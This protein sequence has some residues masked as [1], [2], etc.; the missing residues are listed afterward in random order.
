MLNW[1]RKQQEKLLF[2]VISVLPPYIFMFHLYGKNT[3]YVSYW[4]FLIFSVVLSLGGLLVYWAMSKIGKSRQ[5]SALACVFLWVMFFTIKPIYNSFNPFYLSPINLTVKFLIL[6]PLV[7]AITSIIFVI[8][9]RLKHIGIFKLLAIFEVVVF[10]LNFIPATVV[11]VSGMGVNDSVVDSEVFFS[12]EPSLPSP[13]I[14]W[15]HTDG[16]LGFKAMEYFFDDSQTELKSKLKERGFLINQ[17]AEFEAGHFTEYALVA[18]MSPSVY[19]SVMSPLIT[20]QATPNQVRKKL[21]QYGVKFYKARLNKELI[22]AF[23]TTGYQVHQIIGSAGKWF[24]PTTISYYLQDGRLDNN[25]ANV[26]L[27]TQFYRLDNLINCV[28]GTTPLIVIPKKY[29]DFY[30]RQYYFKRLNLTSVKISDIDTTGIYGN[31]YSKNRLK[32][33]ALSETF[34]KPSPRMVIINVTSAHYPFILDE[35]G[36]TIN[37]KTKKDSLDIQN[38]PPQHRY[39]G[40]YLITL[41]DFILANDPDAIIVAQGDHGLHSSSSSDQILAAGGTVDDVRLIYNQV[42]S[43]VRIPDKWGGLDVPLDPLN[44]TRVLVNRYV[45]QNYELR[46]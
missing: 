28:R 2:G 31:L 37:R 8:G 11:Y 1:L 14:Y 7:L 12:I 6:S 39:T 43:A 18:L 40:R 4:H 45:G 38:Y 41:I 10:L 36:S 9:C 19:D 26:L 25:M 29:I 46:R 5:G 13:N 44:I 15:I 23:E 42:M 30:Y 20:K 21:K 3:E 22:K 34:E 27:C 16:M 35:D 32:I 17:E 33:S 24:F